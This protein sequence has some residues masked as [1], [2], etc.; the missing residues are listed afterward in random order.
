MPEPRD[1]QEA[2]RFPAPER[3]QI[4]IPPDGRPL[5]DQPAWRRDFPIDWPQD[6]YVARRDF[7]KFLVLTS[8][9]FVVGQLWIGV[10]NFYRRRRGRPEIRRVA[11]LSSIPVGATIIFHYPSA[12]DPC[13]LVRLTEDQIVA[14][15]QKCTHLSCAVVPR[16]KEGTFFC[17]CHDGLFDLKTGAALA[18]P[19]PRPLPRIVLEIRGQDIYA[20]GI[21]WRTV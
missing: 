3:E 15:S 4:S 12:D 18:G 19:P 6:H 8:F 20:A 5:E 13:I 7:T 2:F 1:P 21:E 14:Y 11:S 10:Q 17:P 9:A 16:I